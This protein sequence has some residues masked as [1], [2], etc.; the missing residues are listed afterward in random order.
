MKLFIAIVFAV[1]LIGA[2]LCA[3]DIEDEARE[4]SESRL[5]AT[6]IEITSKSAANEVQF[7]IHADSGVEIEVQFDSEGDQE[8]ELQFK[9]DIGGVGEYSGVT[10]P[11]ELSFVD[12]SS[13]T[14]VLSAISSPTAGHSEVTASWSTTDSSMTASVTFNWASQAFSVTDPASGGVVSVPSSALKWSFNVSDFPF[15]DVSGTSVLGLA[16]KLDA[17]EDDELEESAGGYQKRSVD[18]G[19]ETEADQDKVSVHTAATGVQGLFSWATS[20][21]VTVSGVDGQAPISVLSGGVSSGS[22]SNSAE[23]MI[24]F[25]NAA[26][27]SFVSW[28][29]VIGAVGSASG[30]ACSIVVVVAA[31][32]L[33]L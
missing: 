13:G 27:P 18:D 33:M 25:V 17:G 10:S 20:A 14:W 15:T 29:P 6:E 9:L 12:F 31:V 23:D 21:A 26:Q 30:L 22:T 19:S 5:S 24:F 11:S 7:H 3:A 16:V 4:S 2:Q 32:L 28:D 1:L 8:D